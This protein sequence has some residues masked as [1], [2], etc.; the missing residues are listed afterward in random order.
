M[1]IRERFKDKL[2]RYAIFF[3]T[4]QYIPHP[5][6]YEDYLKKEYL[7]NKKIVS[8]VKNGRR[9]YKTKKD[10]LKKLKKRERIY[11]DAFEEAY[12][13]VRV[14]PKKSFWRF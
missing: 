6:D 2:M 4:F 12:Y 1:K 9:Y 13:I 14:S 8:Y 3:M 5:N 10:A 7:K 11:Y